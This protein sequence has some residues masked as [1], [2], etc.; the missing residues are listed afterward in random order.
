[1]TKRMTQGTNT[2]I[3]FSA[4]KSCQVLQRLILVWEIAV[5]EMVW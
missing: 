3:Y 5:L 1:M 2:H 4:R